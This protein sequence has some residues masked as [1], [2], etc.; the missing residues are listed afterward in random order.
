MPASSKN[1]PPFST[2]YSAADWR[3]LHQ[4]VLTAT[5]ESE[6]YAERLR[7]LSEMGQRLNQA[8]HEDEIFRLATDY[9][10]QILPCDRAG[11]ALTCPD[12]NYFNVVTIV[13]DS[14]GI[15]LSRPLPLAGTVIG[16]AI[17]QQKLYYL[18]DLL[19]SD[20]ERVSR[21]AQAGFR[22]FMV[23]PMI[24]GNDPIGAI[25]VA[26]RSANFYQQRDQELLIHIASFLGITVENARRT[27]R[28]LSQQA[29]LQATNQLLE[30]DL[31]LAQRIQHNLLPASHLQSGPLSVACFYQSAKQVGGD[32]Y[33]YAH[34]T[35]QQLTLAVGDVS[36][37]GM[38]AALMMSVT[39]TLLNELL[40]QGLSIPD[41]YRQLDVRLRPYTRST[42]QN[43]ALI[44]AEFSRLPGDAWQLKLGNAGCIP[45]VIRRQDGAVESLWLPG[46]PLGVPL[47]D[48]PRSYQTVT[49]LR[50]G[51]MVIFVTD[52]VVEAQSQGGA[53]FGFEQLEQ[54]VA[55]GPAA[56]AAAMMR[57]LYRQVRTFTGHAQPRDDLTIVVV[58][59]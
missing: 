50:P 11:I 34:D 1:Q 30:A 2:A 27:A 55:A 37:H 53:L 10:G 57:H 15:E 24:V 52:G 54:A 38:A 16:Q 9:T 31:L 32:F 20:Y 58:Q 7:L 33:T 26:S 28:L 45:P 59:V 3:Q 43:C 14:G 13:G 5:A 25:N 48:P 22:S 17:R 12:G 18:P 35:G 19:N 23:A 6:A 56:D 21:L 51:D 8:T 41:V 4:Y 36:G 46:M 39:L 40:P 44:Y 49:P 47:A 42:G 29:E